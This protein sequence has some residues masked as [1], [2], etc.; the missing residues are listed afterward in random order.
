VKYVVARADEIPDGERKIVEV[1]GLSIGV[2]NVGGRYHALLNRC[3]HQGAQ[4]CRGSL[5]GFLEASAPGEFEF[6][7]DR[8][9]LQ[10][11][12]HGWEFDLE[13]GQSYFDPARTR[14]RRYEVELARGQEIAADAAGLRKGPYVAQVFPVR[15]EEDYIVVTLRRTAGATVSR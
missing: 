7:E 6:S 9:L 11:P 15:V 5:L 3:P 12:W 2:F 10:C 13:T 4:L 14:V 8:K 1:R